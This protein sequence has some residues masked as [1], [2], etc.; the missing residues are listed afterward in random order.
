MAANIAAVRLV[1]DDGTDLADKVNPRLLSLR[2]T[3]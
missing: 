2:L 1:L 3:E